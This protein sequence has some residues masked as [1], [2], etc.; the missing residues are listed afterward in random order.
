MFLYKILFIYIWLCWALR[1]DFTERRYES[2]GDVHR[3]SHVRLCAP[4]TGA[5]QAPPPMGFFHPHLLLVTV[6]ACRLSLVAASRGS[7][8]ASVQGLLFLGRGA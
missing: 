1:Y 6:A 3:S 8:P 2:E 4:W 7:S 5:H